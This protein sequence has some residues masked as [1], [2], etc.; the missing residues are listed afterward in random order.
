MHAGVGQRSQ[1]PT[2]AKLTKRER[3][4][5]EGRREGAGGIEVGG[6]EG[7]RESKRKG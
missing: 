5:G 4:L 1:H 2:L 3:E 7:G 6:T